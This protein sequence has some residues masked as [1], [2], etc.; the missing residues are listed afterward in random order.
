M[1]LLARQHT[2]LDMI[3]ET[4]GYLDVGVCAVA[5][6]ADCSQA[7]L[8]ARDSMN[9]VFAYCDSSNLK[10]FSPNKT[11]NNLIPGWGYS[12]LIQSL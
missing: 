11:N 4:G 8:R 3:R 6:L 5:K 1:L 10:Y 2:N 7:A 12:L 9:K